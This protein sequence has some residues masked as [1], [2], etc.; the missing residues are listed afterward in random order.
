MTSRNDRVEG[1]L[2]AT[3][4]GDALGA[5]YEFQPARGPELEVAMVGGGGWEPGEWT[6]DTSMA[7]AIAEVAATGADLRRR[8]GAGRHRRT[9]ARVDSWTPKTSASRPARCS[10]RPDATA[11][12]RR[13]GPAPKR[14]N[15]I[16]APGAP[17]A[18]AR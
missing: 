6:D 10:P 18:T 2:L 7:I 15:C 3:A 4:A 14:P 11:A 5:P 13:R 16:S 12:S 8:G 17:P 1:V 9:V